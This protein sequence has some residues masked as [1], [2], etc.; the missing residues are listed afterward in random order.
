MSIK[1]NLNEQALLTIMTDTSKKAH[2]PAISSFNGIL[3][4]I[5]NHDCHIQSFKYMEQLDRQ[6][7]NSLAKAVLIQLDCAS[8]HRMLTSYSTMEY[9]PAKVLPQAVLELPASLIYQNDRKPE[10]LPQELPHQSPDKTHPFSDIIQKASRTYRL[11]AKLIE[12]VVQVE[13]DFNVKAVS[14]SGAKG[15]MQLMPDTAKELGVDDPFDPV[16]NIMGGSLYLKQLLHRYG[17]RLELALAAY[18]WGMGN[19]EHHS[20]ELPEETRNYIAKVTGL[21]NRSS[22]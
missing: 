10:A 8:F 19:L 3:Q 7:I 11:D 17:G 15:L 21:L 13:S 2:P 12:A 6:S 9:T 20:D 4:K 5:L 14:G 18:N 1:I 22:V 16:Q